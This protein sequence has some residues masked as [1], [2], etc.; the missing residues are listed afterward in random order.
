MVGP[1]LLAQIFVSKYEYHQPLYR[2]EKM[3]PQQFGVELSHKTMGCWV[4]QAAELLKPVYRAI[5]EDLLGSEALNLFKDRCLLPL[6]NVCDL[7]SK[8]KLCSNRL[9][10]HSSVC[11]D[12]LI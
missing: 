6:S 5:K 1:G 4:E 3:F 8:T 7:M 2:Q 12:T 10:G 9:T 11:P